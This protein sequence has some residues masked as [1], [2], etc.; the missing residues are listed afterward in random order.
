MQNVT[1][2]DEVEDEVFTVAEI[3]QGWGI[4]RKVVMRASWCQSDA[5]TRA[6]WHR[7]PTWGSG[8]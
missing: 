4:P 8:S 6:G 5:Q 2:V 7:W 3:E 1:P